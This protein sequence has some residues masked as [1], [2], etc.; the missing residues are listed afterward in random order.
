VLIKLKRLLLTA[1]LLSSIYGAEDV[2]KKE[3]PNMNI[4]SLIE[5]RF[6]DCCA[7]CKCPSQETSDIN[8]LTRIPLNYLS[9]TTTAVGLKG[10]LSPC[11]SNVIGSTFVKTVRVFADN[12]PLDLTFTFTRLRDGSD[13]DHQIQFETILTIPGVSIKRNNAE[14]S[15]LDDSG[16]PMVITFNKCGELSSFDYGQPTE[17]PF[18]PLLY[19]EL[20]AKPIR[21]KLNM[22]HG[23]KKGLHP[24]YIDGSDSQEEGKLS[25]YDGPSLIIQEW[26]FFDYTLNFSHKQ[27]RSHN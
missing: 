16:T 25:A 20:P 21:I 18:A 24:T 13:R 23:M 5:V 27:I 26:S 9:K 6:I 7:W 4:G 15:S 14:G 12:S 8:V 2:E 3:K 19:L 17:G 11:S 10:N 1:S 22:G